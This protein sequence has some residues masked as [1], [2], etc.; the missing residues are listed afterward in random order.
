MEWKLLEINLLYYYLN[1]TSSS[2]PE[3]KEGFLE[4]IFRMLKNINYSEYHRTIDQY[5]SIIHIST[6]I[7]EVKKYLI[8]ISNT[9]NTAECDYINQLKHNVF[10]DNLRNVFLKH[11]NILSFPNI[12]TL[13]VESFSSSEQGIYSRKQIFEKYERIRSERSSKVEINLSEFID[14][15]MILGEN[16]YRIFGFHQFYSLFNDQIKALINKTGF[17]TSDDFFYLTNKNILNS[18]GILDHIELGNYLDYVLRKKEDN[19]IIRKSSIFVGSDGLNQNIVNTINNFMS[20]TK[21]YSIDSFVEF[22]ERYLNVKKKSV[23]SFLELDIIAPIVEKSFY[24]PTCKLL[25]DFFDNQEGYLVFEMNLLSTFSD[26]FTSSID[27]IKDFNTIYKKANYKYSCGVFYCSELGD[28]DKQIFDF[29]FGKYKFVK[30]ETI[31]KNLS[32]K[33]SMQILSRLVSKQLIIAIS[34]NIYLRSDV[35]RNS[36]LLGEEFK[37]LHDII[38]VNRLPKYFSAYTYLIQ[39]ESFLKIFSSQVDSFD[40]ITTLNSLLK[41]MLNQHIEKEIVYLNQI[42]FTTQP[43]GSLESFFVWCLNSVGWRVDDITLIQYCYEKIG[44]EFDID[45]VRI[46]R[47]K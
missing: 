5:R 45:T 46:N 20:I 25:I 15:E 30:V 27:L 40:K 44:I 10:N 38:I 34:K 19:L 41:L 4:E 6:K 8:N 12:H 35:V 23:S 32:P 26:S 11:Q 22:L 13:L 43:D 29:F 7:R 47:N 37:R 3:K 42:I 28:F 1:V 31:N 18:I 33:N 16:G 39:F 9:L 2:E 36:T 17:I 14:N 24:S 21:E